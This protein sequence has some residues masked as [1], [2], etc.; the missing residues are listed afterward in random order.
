L[1]T[2]RLDAGSYQPDVGLFALAD[3]FDS[4]R[5]QFAV[6]AEQRGLRLRVVPTQLAVRSDP[7]LLRRIVQNFVSNALRYTES[8]GVL[9]GARRVGDQVRIDV[10]D[11]GPGIAGE[12]QA[13]IFGEFQRLERPSPWGEKGL[14]LG[15]SICERIAGILGHRLSLASRLGHGSRFSVML[16]RSQT[17]VARRR[18]V[19]QVVSLE[20]LP[21]TVLCLDNDVS[22]LE[23]MRA[24]LQRWGVDCRT[25]VDVS[26]AL[27]ELRKGAID[28]ILADYHLTDDMDGLQAIAHLRDQIV[29]F[30]PV[31]LIT[32]DG[33]SE[34]KQQTRALGYPLLHK[35]IRPAALRALLGALLRKRDVAAQA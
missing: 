19:R 1:D 35:P 7:Q 15:L 20:E 28:L 18:T 25:A 30:P 12:Q 13:R 11:T 4:L 22:I 3:I 29:P 23:G 33:S 21:L 14:G 5:A 6:L 16:P 32:A 10:C 27:N 26:Q 2:S 31:A 34:L 8:G 17:S 24:L 9:L